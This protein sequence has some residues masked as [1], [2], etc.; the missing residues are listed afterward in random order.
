M[1]PKI[2]RPMHKAIEIIGKLSYE[3]GYRAWSTIR[4]KK[5]LINEF[6]DLEEKR[7][8]FSYKMIFHRTPKELEKAVREMKKGDKPL[9]ILLFLVKEPGSND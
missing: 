2:L 4:F 8:I 3:E 1:E 7:A 5:R 9:P 6:P